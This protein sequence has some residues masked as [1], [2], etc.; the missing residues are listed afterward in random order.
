MN[1]MKK[2][3]LIS[4]TFLF[5]ALSVIIT[6]CSD[7]FLD[8]KVQ[9]GV[10][11][12]T[13][14]N[15]AQKLVTGVYNS[16][17]QGDSWG[18]GDVHGFAFIAVTNIMSDDADKGSTPSDQA[19]PVGDLDNF[20]ITP[21]NRF[22]E[23]LWSGHY[24]GIGAA[25]Q[26][27]AALPNASIDAQVK[28]QLTGEVKFLRGYLYF[29][30]VRMYG[31][32]PLVL[33]VPADATDANTDPAFQTRAAVSVV[34]DSIARDLQY[35][36]DNLPLK[37]ATGDGHATKGAAQAL[38]AKV[39]LYQQKWPQVFTL[40]AEVINSGKYQLLQDYATIWRQAGDN[41]SESIF[42]IQTGKFNN[43]NL[44]IDNYTTCQ[45]PRTG[46]SGGWDDLGWGFNTPSPNLVNAYEPNDS[47]KAAT[48]IFINN[49][50]NHKGTVLWDGRRIPSSD[51]VQNLYYNYKAYTSISK[52]Q[53]ANTADKDRPKNIKVLR[54]ADVLLMY[55]EAA[56]RT[57][58]GDATGKINLLRQR[59]NLLP[60]GAVTLD[61][62]LKERH[63][64]LAMEHDRYWD[65]VRQGKAA[66]VMLAAGKS[67]FVAGK[68]ELL[69][70]PNSQ[71]LLSG[72][73]LVQNP[74]Y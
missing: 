9:G 21:T 57:G 55:A 44:K 20:T 37:G 51:S 41:S 43:A 35:A 6:S 10:T 36:A 23:S 52:E 62:V 33:R 68:H 3:V 38:L 32:V 73:K 1:N 50:G 13:D 48:I 45:G 54:Y 7:N 22:A 65:L 16:L 56:V 8:V 40:T 71:I 46:G 26:A 2:I 72:N 60:K 15:L 58:S 63:I 28:K 14:P 61:D 18:N 34:Y 29:N 42:E 67:N 70:I 69:P 31:G 11:T 4:F 59:A 53:Y 39:Y 12:G 66:Q 49:T 30:L 74:G 24:N 27:L 5:F 17:M 25:N 47:R 64:E 19:V